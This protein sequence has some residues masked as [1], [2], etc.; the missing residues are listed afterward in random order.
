MFV[1][2]CSTKYDLT[3]ADYQNCTNSSVLYCK[4]EAVGLEVPGMTSGERFVFDN[5]LILSPFNEM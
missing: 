3:C 1:E 5:A 4:G 2:K